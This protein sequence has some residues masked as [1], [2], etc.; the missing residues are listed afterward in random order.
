MKTLKSRDHMRGAAND[1]HVATARA[2]SAIRKRV[3]EL[4]VELFLIGDGE[5]ATGL[6]SRVTWVLAIGVDI[7]L[8]DRSAA[9]RGAEVQS[10]LYTVL[11]LAIEGGRWRADQADRIWVSMHQACELMVEHPQAAL[12]AQ[13]Q[14]ASLAACVRAASRRS[15]GCNVALRRRAAH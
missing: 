10:T 3:R 6:L 15:A 9:A 14:A 1:H 5:R 7:S 4:S 2:R 11:Q 8:Q 12:A 13:P